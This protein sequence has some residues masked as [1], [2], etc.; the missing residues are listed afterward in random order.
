MTMN[1]RNTK[2]IL[3]LGVVIIFVVVVAGFTLNSL[4]SPGSEYKDITVQQAM[5]LIETNPSLVIVDVR[6][7][8]EFSSGPLYGAINIPVDSLQQ[9]LNELNPN[10]EILVYCR[11]GNRSRGRFG[12]EFG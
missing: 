12:S 4:N 7:E 11:T 1:K 6:T 5:E 9:R 8:E 10:D 3:Y 2:K